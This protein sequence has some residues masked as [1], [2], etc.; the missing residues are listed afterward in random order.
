MMMLGK[1]GDACVTRALEIHV[2]HSCNLSCDGCRHYSN[3]KF[4]GH[5]SPDTMEAWLSDW[6]GRIKP[7]KFR[8]VG[9]EPTLNPDLCE[10]VRIAA[11]HW[12]DSIRQVT[13]NGYFL[14]RQPD[15]VQTLQDTNTRIAISVHSQS[16]EYLDHIKRVQ[17]ALS[18][19]QDDSLI[20]VHFEE[21]EG[22]WSRNYLGNGYDMRPYKD[23][24]AA[25]SWSVCD[26]KK[27]MQLHEGKLWKCP[28][29]AYLDQ[30]L[31]KFDLKDHPDW[32]DY[33]HY[34]PLSADASQE[35]LETFLNQKVEDI[36]AMCPANPTMVQDKTIHWRDDFRVKK[37]A[38]PTLQ[39]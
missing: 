28:P 2:T 32:R 24:N 9:G 39:A 36:C 17:E 37:T 13:S 7:K 8:L 15:L 30:V 35:E 34:V 1:E 14:H 23:A 22:D 31:S 10:L 25:R 3:Y 18:Y 29:I 38:R 11:R 21:M 6:S 4:K 16:P 5:L 27:C 33:T 26:C 20:E 12:P 19:G